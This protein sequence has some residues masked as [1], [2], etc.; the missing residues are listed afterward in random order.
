MLVFN[1]LLS[2]I[3]IYQLKK[4]KNRIKYVEG[5]PFVNHIS[6][7]WLP[8]RHVYSVLKA[9]LSLTTSGRVPHPQAHTTSAKKA[10]L[11]TLTLTGTASSGDEE[12]DDG[13]GL[14]LN[15]WF[16]LF[17]FLCHWFSEPPIFPI[18]LK[19]LSFSV[20]ITRLHLI[21]FCTTIPNKRIN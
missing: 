12:R 18:W 13:L 5:P 17:Q 10:R 11:S 20:K 3:T 14:S 8:K 21:N 2:L 15:F 1:F 7:R 16:S 19:S 9:K 4:N 6:K